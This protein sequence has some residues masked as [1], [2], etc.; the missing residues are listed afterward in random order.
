MMNIKA[1]IGKWFWEQIVK[2]VGRDRLL[3]LL[4]E[5]EVCERCGSDNIVWWNDKYYECDDCDYLCKSKN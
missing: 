4:S 3:S 5:P 1:K 2:K